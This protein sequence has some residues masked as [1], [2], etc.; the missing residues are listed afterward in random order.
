MGKMLR[1]LWGFYV[2]EITCL[3]YDQS[4]EPGRMQTYNLLSDCSTT[5]R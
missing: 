3:D 4:D 2:V 1:H 5:Q